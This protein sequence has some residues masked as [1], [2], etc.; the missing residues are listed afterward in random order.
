M[1]LRAQE[2]PLVSIVTPT[3]NMGRFIKQTIDS[4]LMQDY[5]HIDY[6]VMDGAST[7]DTLEIL[8]TYGS[9]LRYESVP[10]HG[11]ADAINKG[12]A[13]SR[14][15]IF[16]YL[17]ADDTYLPG[18]VS[19]AVRNM[20]DNPEMAVVYGEANYVQ[21]DGSHISRYPTFP[22]DLELLNRRCFIC[23]PAAFMWSDVFQLAGGL[24]ADLHF[25]LDYDLWMR[26]AKSHPMLKIDEV[27]ATSRMYKDNKTLAHRRPVYKEIIGAVKAHYGY[28]PFEWVFA[29][30]CY[31]VDGKDQFFDVAQ[32]S[33]TEILLSLFLGCNYNRNHLIRYWRDWCSRVGSG[34]KVRSGAIPGPG[35]TE[36]PVRL[37]DRG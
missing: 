37:R 10:D 4:V 6:I 1:Q 32:P 7:D 12:F 20:R 17:N 5:P 28:V 8:K 29:Y 31:I 23:Q 34:Y 25:A 14:G 11:Q 26:V 21:E 13:L 19:T 35:C 36:M 22:F 30:A 15:R 24:N 2:Y 3:Y 27:L 9:R 33:F 16:A 18:A